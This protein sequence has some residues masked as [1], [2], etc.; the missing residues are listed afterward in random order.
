MC[1]IVERSV[2]YYLKISE[3]QNLKISE[4]QYTILLVSSDHKNLL[5]LK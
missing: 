1:Y 2:S 3:F 4:F 5:N